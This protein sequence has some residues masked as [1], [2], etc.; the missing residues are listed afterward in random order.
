MRPTASDWNR[1]A[2]DRLQTNGNLPSQSHTRRRRR[3]HRSLSLRKPAKIILAVLIISAIT[4]LA[5][6]PWQGSDPEHKPELPDVAPIVVVTTAIPSPTP[7]M[8]PPTPIAL[9]PTYTPRPTPAPAPV[10][11]PPTLTPFPNPTRDPGELVIAAYASCAGQYSGQEL[12]SRAAAA[13]TTLDRG[14]RTVDELRQIVV[15]NCQADFAASLPPTSIPVEAHQYP[16]HVYI[17]AYASCN[18]LYSGPTKDQ[19]YQTIQAAIDSGYQT[20]DGL[21]TIIDSRCPSAEHAAA[22]VP[23]ATPTPVPTTNQSWTGLYQS[24]GQA[25]S[26]DRDHSSKWADGSNWHDG[27]SRSLPE[28]PLDPNQPW[29]AQI[30]CAQHEVLSMTAFPDNYDVNTWHQHPN[31]DHIAALWEARIATIFW[32]N[33]PEAPALQAANP[34][35]D[36]CGLLMQ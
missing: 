28:L 21:K 27:R 31:A 19:R 32:G 16:T 24:W 6:F 2:N 34:F 35:G 30:T 8:G 1:V 14:Y 15:E 36:Y 4:G 29:F 33:V 13:Q 23:Q 20:I 9:R 18:D 3:R 11:R 5:I 25:L 7:T 22:I 17:E 12:E 26:E 10:S